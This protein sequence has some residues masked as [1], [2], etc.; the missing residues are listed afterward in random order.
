M[1][2]RH[3]NKLSIFSQVELY[4][5]YHDIGMVVTRTYNG[6]GSP[7]YLG[8]LEYKG[9]RLYMGNSY[10]FCVIKEARDTEPEVLVALAVLVNGKTIYTSS[11]SVCFKVPKFT[12]VGR[13]EN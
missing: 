9:E 10:G 7:C 3:I 12:V 1:K 2:I 4:L 11:E 8:G 6:D 13:D 5:E